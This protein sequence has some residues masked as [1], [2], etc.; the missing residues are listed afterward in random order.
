MMR[1]RI[2][3]DRIEERICKIRMIDGV[4]ANYYPQEELIRCKDCKYWTRESASLAGCLINITGSD[5]KE[6][7]F[8]SWAERKDG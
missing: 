5:C 6:N 2:P 7:D 4:I 3:E 1:G 8:C